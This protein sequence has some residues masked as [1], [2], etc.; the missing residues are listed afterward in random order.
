MT[1]PARVDPSVE[2]PCLCGHKQDEHDPLAAR[3]CQATIAGALERGCMCAQ[4]S[5]PL[6]V[7]GTRY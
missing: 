4:E 6:R 7:N 3:Y 1:T 5:S 2:E